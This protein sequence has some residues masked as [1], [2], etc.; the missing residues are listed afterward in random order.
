MPPE[1]LDARAAALFEQRV[2]VAFGQLQY[3]WMAA[4]AERDAAMQRLAE[5][6]AER[7][8]LKAQQQQSDAPTDS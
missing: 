1:S 3:E 6:T 8:Q 2:K 4:C 5:V 7:D